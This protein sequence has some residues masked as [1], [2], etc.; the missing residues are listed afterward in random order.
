MRRSP[1]VS[2]SQSSAVKLSHALSSAGHGIT[3]VEV[4]VEVDV[5]VLVDVDVDV[6]GVHVPHNAGQSFL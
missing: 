4:E 6:D 1:N 5:V 2:L 3:T